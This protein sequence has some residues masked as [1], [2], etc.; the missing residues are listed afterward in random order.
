MPHL[1]AGFDDNGNPISRS[2]FMVPCRRH[3]DCY[4][5]GRHPLTGQFFQ[6]QRRHTFYDTVRTSGGSVFEE[7][8]ITFLNVSSASASAF[9]ID[10]EEGAI[11]GMTGVC[12]DLDSSMNEGCGNEIAANIKDGLIGCFDGEFVAKFLCGLSLT[13]KHGDLSTV[14]TEGN[15]FW[16]RVL[17]NGSEDSNGDGQG[18]MH[19]ECTDPIDCL[20]K[21]RFLERSSRHGFG[22]PPACALYAPPFDP[23][24]PPSG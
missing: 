10:M 16:P 9:D 21:C 4:S 7:N 24:Q 1:T 17:L 23:T 15:L 22:A 18:G 13:V 5:C 14:Q 8:G 19:L 6:C 11:T 20:Q 3:S 2:G 12:V